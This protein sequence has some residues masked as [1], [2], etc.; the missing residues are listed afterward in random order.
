MEYKE[1]TAKTVS[2]AITE[3]CKYYSVPSD[4]LDYE[5]VEEGSS[6][7]F[8]IGAKAAVIKAR[9]KVVEIKV[10][11]PAEKP[12]EKPVQNKFEKKVE[13]QEEKVVEKTAEKPVEKATVKETVV[14]KEI[15]KEEAEK[16]AKEFLHNVFEAMEMEECCCL[17]SVY[18]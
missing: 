13:K 14:K 6:G 17:D 10:E 16:A 15:N 5:V 18:N 1:F 7:F 2:D 12:V 11:K 9:E 8:G 4:R 3:A